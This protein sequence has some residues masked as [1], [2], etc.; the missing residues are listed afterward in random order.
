[1]QTYIVASD[2]HGSLSAA[3]TVIEAYHLHKADGILLLGD[4]LYHGPRNDLPKDYQP[5]EVI[6]LLNEYAKDI[7]CVRGNCDTEVDQMVLEFPILADYSYFQLGQ[8]RCFLSHGHLYTPEPKSFLKTNDL[9][10]SGHTHIPTA[11]Q[12][13]GIYFLNPGSLSLPKQN[14]SP[15]YAVLSPTGF[16]T[17]RINHEVYAISCRF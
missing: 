16:Q 14:H 6:R 1:M 5:K 17:Y 8:H 9:F 13:E 10:L 2:L 11:D 7:L 12:K 4:I 15:S 3:Q